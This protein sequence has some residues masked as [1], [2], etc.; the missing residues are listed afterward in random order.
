MTRRTV[1]GVVVA[2]IVLVAGV[3]VYMTYLAPQ[4][5]P[6]VTE[7]PE[8]TARVVPATGVVVPFRWATLSFQMGGRVEQVLVDEG[9][10]VDELQL[11]VSLDGGDLQ[12]AVAQAEAALATAQA[13]LAQVQALPR[14]EE[15]A[16]AR[17]SLASAQAQLSKLRTGATQEEI[18]AARG[19][20]ETA[21]LAVQQAQA[22]YDEVAWLEEIREMPQALALQQATAEYE[23][24]RANYDALVKGPSSDDIAMAQADVDRARASLA[25]LMAGARPEDIAVAEASLAQAEL[26]LS[27]ARSALE[28]AELRAPFA[29]TVGAV[30][31]REGEMLSPGVPAVVLGD[32]SD[33]KV[34]TTDLNEIEIHLLRVGQD[35]ALT[36]DAL[37]ERTIRG[38]VTHISPMANLEQGGTNFTVTIEL[39]EQ[40]PDLR[41]GMT[42]F[43]DILVGDG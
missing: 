6:E 21:T 34:E 1:I 24:A 16:V 33:F 29:A 8:E 7:E 42:A 25:L 9:D 41:W 31:V 30:N 27:Q 28:D 3:W 18:T 38:T 26:A 15:L 22:A 36:F 19:A 43:V 14:D 2:I 12:D 5:E 4:P 10:L 17:A 20:L 39:E 23:I 32:V 35:V 13:T 37:P 40:D 11:L